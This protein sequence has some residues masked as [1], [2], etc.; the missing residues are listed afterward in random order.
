M[1][2]INNYIIEK[3]HIT[4]KF[5]NEEDRLS[6]NDF[7]FYLNDNGYVLNQVWKSSY[8]IFPKKKIRGDLYTTIIK[9]EDYFIIDTE[10][11]TDEGLIYINKDKPTNHI[12][13]YDAKEEGMDI[14]R[15]NGHNTFDYTKN[16]ADILIRLI[17][18]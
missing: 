2:D 10:Q 3:L 11:H 9:Y 18:K 12:A 15:R 4:K 1:K 5:K 6:E 13:S 16:N 7:V 14:T 8:Y 17:G